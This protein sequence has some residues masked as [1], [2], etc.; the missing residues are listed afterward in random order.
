MR[1]RTFNSRLGVGNKVPGHTVRDEDADAAAIK[2]A[3]GRL[4]KTK[5]PKIG[6]NGTDLWPVTAT[7]HCGTL[8]KLS[9]RLTGPQW[10]VFRKTE[11]TC[12]R[13]SK[14]A[15]ANCW[16][17]LRPTISLFSPTCLRQHPSKFATN[18]RKAKPC[19]ETARLIATSG[20]CHERHRSAH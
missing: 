15:C 9:Q 14:R 3:L 6:T 17:S 18:W 2:A 7:V 10:G 4:E 16:T 19:L 5:S 8:G 11:P 20:G 12:S 13:I 1:C